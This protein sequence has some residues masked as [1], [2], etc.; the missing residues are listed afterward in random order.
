MGLFWDSCFLVAVRS[1]HPNNSPLFK[2]YPAG[3]PIP[4]SFPRKWLKTGQ[5]ARPG[6]RDS[7]LC[8]RLPHPKA[9]AV[10]DAEDLPARRAEIDVA[11]PQ[12]AADFAAPHLPD[13]FAAMRA[14][15]RYVF[16]VNA[17]DHGNLSSPTATEMITI[18]PVRTGLTAGG[19]FSAICRRGRRH[20]RA[21]E[22]PKGLAPPSPYSAGITFRARVLRSLSLRDSLS[23]L[24]S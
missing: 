19:F 15:R 12:E 3:Q 17:F 23:A 8:G 5:K 7:W 1:P 9:L 11:F 6:W 24:L 21:G 22:L 13:R 16:L 2:V 14:N 10:G 18:M 4:G 20:G